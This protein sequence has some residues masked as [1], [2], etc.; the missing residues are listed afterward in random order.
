V[1]LPL[2][3]RPF[4]VEPMGIGLRGVTLRFVHEVRGEADYSARHGRL[5]SVG[6]AFLEGKPM[7]AKGRLARRISPIACFSA[8]TSADQAFMAARARASGKVETGVLTG[9]GLH[10]SL[11]LERVPAPESVFHCEAL[12]PARSLPTGALQRGARQRKQKAV[13]FAC[14]RRELHSRTLISPRQKSS[15]DRQGGRN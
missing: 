8:G 4:L 2:R 9:A 10:G 7:S 1:V 11:G 12:F 14:R 3:E 13:L 15:P 5:P 6:L